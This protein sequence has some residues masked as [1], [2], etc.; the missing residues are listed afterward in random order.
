MDHS[1][2]PDV[3][4]LKRLQLALAAI[5]SD[6]DAIERRPHFLLKRSGDAIGQTE[7]E[8]AS[9][10]STAISYFAVAV[11]KNRVTSGD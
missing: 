9:R 7:A 11:A 10:E 6:L 3:A 2:Q 5:S 8:P 1:E 4:E